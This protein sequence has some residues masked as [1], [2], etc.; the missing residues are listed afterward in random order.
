MRVSCTMRFLLAS[1]VVAAASPPL[2]TVD[3]DAAA[4]QNVTALDVTDQHEMLAGIG[5]VMALIGIVIAFFVGYY[6]GTVTTRREPAMVIARSAGESVQTTTHYTLQQPVHRQ[7][8]SL[9]VM[10]AAAAAADESSGALTPKDLAMF[11][12]YRVHKRN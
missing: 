7:F 2:H 9:A 6:I 11:D 4:A 3:A 12:M 5:I 10:A 1:L 8:S